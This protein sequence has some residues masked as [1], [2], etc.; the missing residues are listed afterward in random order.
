MPRGKSLKIYMMDGEVT[1]RW[2]CT[3]LIQKCPAL[4]KDI[5]EESV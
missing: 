3:L 4:Q 2:M 5:I 1:G